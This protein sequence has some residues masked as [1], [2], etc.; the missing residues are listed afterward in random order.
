MGILQVVS[1]GA[2]GRQPHLLEL[3]LLH[4]LLIWGDSCALDTNRVLLDSFGGIKCYLVV[5]LVAVWQTKVVVLEVNIEVWVNKLQS[6]AHVLVSFL[7][8]GAPCP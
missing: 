8:F 7:R 4:A 6:S 3:E 5:C 1:D 2:V